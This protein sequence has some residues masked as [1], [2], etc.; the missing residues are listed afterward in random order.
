MN[1]LQIFWGLPLE[2]TPSVYA[3]SMLYPYTDNFLDNPEVNSEE[4][5][6]LKA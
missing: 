6:K 3:Y 4:K 5:I 1:S 2:M